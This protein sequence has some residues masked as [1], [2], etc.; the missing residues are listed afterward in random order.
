MLTPDVVLSPKTPRIGFVHRKLASGDL[1]FVVNTSNRSHH[2]QATF[3]D[4]AKHAEWW[5]PFTGGISSVKN[6]SAVDLDLQPYESRLILFADDATKTDKTQ[7]AAHMVLKTIDLTTNWNLTFSHTNRTVPMPKLHSWSDDPTL[8]YYS[9][10]V[11]YEKSFAL[12]SENVHSAGSAV[13]D[14]GEGRPIDEPNPLPQY[15]MKAY[16]EAPIRD[17]AEVYVNGERAGFVWHP[18]YTID[19]TNFLRTGRNTV[20]MVVGNTAINSLAGH[21]LP[22]YHLLNERYGERSTPQDMGNLQALPS[23]ILGGLRLDLSN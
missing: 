3:R 16:F 13:L 22:P 15:S 20:R 5:D 6:P 4:A 11:V 9:G 2:V 10:Q 19:V 1:Y 14:F 7:P 17:A 23:G 18:P 12:S 8:K 21:A